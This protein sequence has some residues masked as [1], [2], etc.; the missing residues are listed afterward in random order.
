M[1]LR[2]LES[3]ET[4]ARAAG[5]SLKFVQAR[6][7]EEL[8]TG[9]VT[10]TAEKIATAYVVGDALWLTHDKRAA[11]TAVRHRVAAIW[12]H[13]SI[14]DAGG[15]M[16]YAPDLADQW[17]LSAGYVKRILTGTP[18]GDLPLQYPS[19]WMLVVNLKAAKAIGVTVSPTTVARADRVIE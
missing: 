6:S 19:R 2:L 17:R 8:D 7:L 12:G 5:L 1:A 9:L 16:A 3:W 10:L 18:A 13:T 14:A 15:L 4:G 11:E